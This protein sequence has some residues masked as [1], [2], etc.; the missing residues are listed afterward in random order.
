MN[1]G[2]SGP[3]TDHSDVVRRPKTEKELALEV[4]LA[5]DH[6][7][8]VAELSGR[9]PRRFNQRVPRYPKGTKQQ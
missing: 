8:L 3:N 1:S 9:G 5:A 4:Q 2:N 6:D 7:A